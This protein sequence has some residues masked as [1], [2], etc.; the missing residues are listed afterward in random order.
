[1]EWGYLLL[2]VLGFVIWWITRGSGRPEIG[3]ARAPVTDELYTAVT[4]VSDVLAGYGHQVQWAYVSSQVLTAV[5]ERC[6]GSLTAT[7]G[8][9]ARIDAGPPLADLAGTPARC[10]GG[11]PR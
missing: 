11:A 7:A 9:Y 3:S 4:Q 5:C 1:V 8:G 10:P 2:P 6:G